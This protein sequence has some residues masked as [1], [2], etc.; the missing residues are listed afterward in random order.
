MS[1]VA[2]LVLAIA[3]LLRLKVE[4]QRCMDVEEGWK[5]TRRGRQVCVVSSVAWC[6]C[7]ETDVAA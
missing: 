1:G 4:R 7:R 3:A 6:G 2:A 5:V